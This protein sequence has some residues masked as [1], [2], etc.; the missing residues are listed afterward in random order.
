M[1]NP[2]FAHAFFYFFGRGWFSPGA[3]VR[4]VEN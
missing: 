3:E 1:T 2:I 4:C